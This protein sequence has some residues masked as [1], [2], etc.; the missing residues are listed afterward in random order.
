MK[1]FFEDDLLSRPW[2]DKKKSGGGRKQ[3]INES[4]RPRGGKCRQSQ[5]SLGNQPAK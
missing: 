2:E 5:R 4:R 1:G 3:N